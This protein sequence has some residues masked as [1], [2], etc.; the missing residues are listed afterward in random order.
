MSKGVSMMLLSC[1]GGRMK[2]CPEVS[3]VLRRWSY[4]IDL[5]V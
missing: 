3:P 4:I 5:T 1:L 2:M